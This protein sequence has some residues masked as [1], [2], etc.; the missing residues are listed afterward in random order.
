MCFPRNYI[1]ADSVFM[2]V[3]SPIGRGVALYL[4]CCGR[5]GFDP[6]WDTFFSGTFYF[7]Y[8]SDPVYAWLIHK[9]EKLK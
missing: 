6:S 8:F 5:S 7:L 2:V 1:I 9:K 3:G 4:C